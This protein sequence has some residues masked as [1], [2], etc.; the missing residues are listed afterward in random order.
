MLY[1]CIQ[2]SFLEIYQWVNLIFHQKGWPSQY[3]YT[4]CSISPLKIAFNNIYFHDFDNEITFCIETVTARD[5]LTKDA[6]SSVDTLT[7]TSS[8]GTDNIRYLQSLILMLQNRSFYVH[9]YPY[10]NIKYN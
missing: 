6:S 4:F 3:C 7:G 10:S 1:L 5:I 9:G 8:N 2:K